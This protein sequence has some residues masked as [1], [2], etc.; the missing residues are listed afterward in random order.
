MPLRSPNFAPIGT[1]WRTACLLLICACGD[2][3]ARPKR[4]RQHDQSHAHADMDS[5]LPPASDASVATPGMV[6]DAALPSPVVVHASRHG[7]EVSIEFENGESAWGF[8]QSYCSP[9]RLLKRVEADATVL[10]DDRPRGCGKAFYYADGSYVGNVT[11]A[12]CLGCDGGD[13]CEP[14]GAKMTLSTLEYVRVGSRPA[15]SVDD[16]G[17]AE[18][19]AELPVIEPRDSVGPYIVHI[20]YRPDEC[21]GE[22]MVA[23]L[24]VPLK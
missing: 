6:P 7:S 24:P 8:F 2:E 14:L 21:R 5:G 12:V 9:P 1:I 11:D 16:A 4:E 13:V 20:E 19:E 15:P 10:R 3:S 23:E 18:T 17:T 22:R